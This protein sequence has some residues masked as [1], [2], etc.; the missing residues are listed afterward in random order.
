M[1]NKVLSI[2]DIGAI[3]GIPDKKQLMIVV[4][5][6]KDQGNDRNDQQQ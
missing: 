2:Y 3:E 4:G 5:G 6:Q 1:Y